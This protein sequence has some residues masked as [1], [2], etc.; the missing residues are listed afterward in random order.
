MALLATLQIGNNAEG[1][2]NNQ[3][4]VV[5]CNYSFSRQ[6]N[7]RVPNTVAKNNQ[8]ELVLVAPSCDDM[9]LYDWYI[10]Q[11]VLSGRIVFDM[12]SVYNDDAKIFQ[13][14]NAQCYALSESYDID[15]IYRRLITLC[16]TAESSQCDSEI[17]NN[18]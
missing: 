4:L 13:F 14:E 1:I 18:H 8:V 15:G 9:L 17:F 12:S 3:Y 6:H 5:R 7:V 16:I 2:Y 10:N 11:D